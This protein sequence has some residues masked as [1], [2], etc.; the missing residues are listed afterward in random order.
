MAKKILKNRTQF[1][2]T[3]ENSLYKG[4]QDMSKET[5]VPISKLLD[6]AVVPLVMGHRMEMEQ[7]KPSS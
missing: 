1:T 6:C 5:N 2:S 7:R 4:L 3:L